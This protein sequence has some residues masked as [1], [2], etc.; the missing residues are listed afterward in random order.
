MIS[1]VKLWRNQKRVS[2]G[3]GLTGKIISWTLV[4]VPPANFSDQAPYPVVIVQLTNRKKISAM[5]VDYDESDL[6][7]GRKVVTVVRRLIQ[8]T[9]E[10]IIPYDIKVK[11]I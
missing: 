2:A 5:L 9:S 6:T 4:R 3:V 7:Y 11:P 1:P 8:P 10:G